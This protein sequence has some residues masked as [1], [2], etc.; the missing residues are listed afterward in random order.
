MTRR[1]V[2]LAIVAALL[3]AC[4]PADADRPSAEGSQ[5]PAVAAVVLPDLSA[6]SPSV[7]QQLRH[8][9]D[10]ANAAS[11]SDAHASAVAFAAL[12]R[13]LMA[14]T[15]TDEA[16]AAFA[17]AQAFE[18]G[19]AQWTYLEGH[20]RLRKG[21]RADAVTAFTRAAALAP[22][23]ATLQV[24]L[25]EAQLDD[26]DAA[27]ARRTFERACSLQPQSA[28]AWFGAGRAAL[29]QQDY[30]GAA[31][32]LAEALRLEPGATAV[33]Y[34]LAM[35]YRGLG[36]R[37]QAD[38]HLRRRGAAY[39][40][41]PDPFMQA[42]D[43]LLDSA[44]AYEHRGMQALRGAD[45]AAAE[46]AFRRGLALAP[47]DPSLRYWLGAALFAAGNRA[48][49][50]REFLA[51]VNRSPDFAKA[52]FSLGMVY[53]S[54]GRKREALERFRLAVAHDAGM[55]EARLRLAD[56]LRGAGDQ[57]GALAQYQQ[58]VRIDPSMVEAWIGGERLL[59][60]LGRGRE[61]EAWRADARRLHPGRQEFA[62]GPH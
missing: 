51:V 5:P 34:P 3:V 42:D 60:S 24:W 19:V 37:G 11:P 13:L 22:A 53:E 1:T 35:A 10:A 54:S 9:V 32:D 14:A 58:A 39:P 55:P 41:L 25:G 20:A 12:G 28:A 50:E 4:A 36:D 15:F 52:H 61:A 56:A 49:A 8:A 7:Q 48:A 27:G 40:S 16:A 2:P 30:A 6:L 23:D 38:Q 45:F 57:A 59:V 43:Q 29:A 46:A 44:V 18:P 26:G 33:H 21:R 17:R 47:D 62:A 31:R